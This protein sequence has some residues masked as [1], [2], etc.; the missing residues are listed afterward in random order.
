MYWAAR[1]VVVPRTVKVIES[2]AFAGMANLRTLRFEPGSALERVE[3]GAFLGT[4][5]RKV[6][7]PAGALVAKNWKNV[8][9]APEWYSPCELLL[10]PIRK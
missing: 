10:V 4:N 2:W 3:P 8:K 7:F 5:L 6:K 1:E 9:E